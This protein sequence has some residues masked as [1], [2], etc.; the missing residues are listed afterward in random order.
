MKAALDY[1]V[2]AKGPVAIRYPKEIVNQNPQESSLS[3]PYQKGKSAVVRPCSGTIV[4]A[5]VGPVLT[6]AIK[7]ADILKQEGIEIGVINV[8]FAK[9]ADD[10]IVELFAQGKT[11]II[12]EDH[13]ISCGFGSAVLEKAVQ[14]AYLSDNTSMKEAIGRTVLLGGADE[15]IAAAVRARQLDWMGLS[16]EKIVCTVKHLSRMT[17]GSKNR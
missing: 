13:G 14:Q 8:R 11:V 17:I 12:A 5:A 16:A 10:A 7:A 3:I 1:A 6:E 15:F 9:P 2:M 4:I